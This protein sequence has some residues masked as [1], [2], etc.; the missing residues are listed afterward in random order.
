MWDAQE[1][2]RSSS[3]YEIELTSSAFRVNEDGILEVATPDLDRDPPNPSTLT[4]QVLHAYHISRFEAKLR[5]K[6]PAGN[7]EEKRRYGDSTS[8]HFDTFDGRERPRTSFHVFEARSIPRRRNATVSHSGE[9]VRSYTVDG[10]GHNND[11]RLL[12]SRQVV[13]ED[14]DFGEFGKVEYRITDVTSNGKSK[15][16]VNPQTGDIDAIGILRQGDKYILT[17]QVAWLFFH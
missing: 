5:P 7:R 9:F 1:L 4:F 2:A 10:V 17:I 14:K 3:N 12:A 15:F 6:I 8:S 16:A 11:T 13:A